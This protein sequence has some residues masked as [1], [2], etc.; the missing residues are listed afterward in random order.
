MTSIKVFTYNPLV[1]VHFEKCPN[2]KAL[3]ITFSCFT[4]GYIPL[5]K[6]PALSSMSQLSSLYLLYVRVFEKSF[7]AFGC[8]RALK[9][10]EFEHCAFECNW[11]SF[12]AV[13]AQ[14]PVKSIIFKNIDCRVKNIELLLDSVRLDYLYLSNFNPEVGTETEFEIFH[15]FADAFHCQRENPRKAFLIEQDG[16]ARNHNGVISKQLF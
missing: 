14:T 10:L 9:T 15:T 5:R 12:G 11:K 8:L 1:D 7:D 6:I 4:A 2:L 3:K 13:L 16:F